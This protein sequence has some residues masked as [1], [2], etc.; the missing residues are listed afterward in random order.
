MGILKTFNSN[1]LS[2]YTFFSFQIDLLRLFPLKRKGKKMSQ[3]D[4]FKY[5][6]TSA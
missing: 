3:K 4:D 5:T 1:K 2:L 6:D